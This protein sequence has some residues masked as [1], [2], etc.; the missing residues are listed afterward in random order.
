MDQHRRIIV[1]PVITEKATNLRDRN[2][3]TF[4][5]ERRANKVQISQ[6]VEALFEVNVESVRTVSVPRKPKKQGMFSGFKA[7]WKKAYVTL[8]QGDSIDL[9]ENV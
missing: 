5:V 7:G 6:A 3:Y 1:A 4:K 8:R 9:V 2:V